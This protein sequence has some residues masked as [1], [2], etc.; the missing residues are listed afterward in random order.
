MHG[1]LSEYNLLW[2]TNRVFVID[3]SQSVESDH[4][5]ALDFLRKDVANVNDYFR[6]TG[7]LSVMSTRQLFEFVTST[8]IEDTEEYESQALDEIMLV[9][10]R[11]TDRL[12]KLTVQDQKRRLQKEQ[13]DEA[14]FMSQFL[15]RSLNQV[16]DV[17]IKQMEMGEVEDSYAEAVAALT[18]NRDVVAAVVQKQRQ[19]S[20]EGGHDLLEIEGENH[21]VEECSMVDDSSNDERSGNDDDSDD[22][23]DDDDRF[24]KKVMTPEEKE[25]AKSERRAA[26]KAHKKTVKEANSAKRQAKIKKKDKRRAINKTRGNKKK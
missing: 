4:P 18:G 16:A 1:D 11:G 24:I 22:E 3:V 9:V 6:K 12:S 5:S 2:H 10:E 8:V 23:E 21:A 26:M 13:V 7:G 17:D 19:I 20:L 15:P 14:V 25:A